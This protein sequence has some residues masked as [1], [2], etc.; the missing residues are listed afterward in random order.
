MNRKDFL[1]S[2]L[3]ALGAHEVVFR[4]EQPDRISGTVV[5]DPVDSE[6]QQD[7]VWQASE[8]DVPPEDV[9]RLVKLIHERELLDID[10]LTVSRDELRRLFNESY[11]TLIGRADF[12]KIVESL[13]AVTVDMIDDGQKV[14]T[15]FIHE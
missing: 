12:D 3:G 15:Y 8:Q 14:D 5:Y 10:K 13:E 1:R 2:F 7:F 4:E 6:E 9:F 11:N